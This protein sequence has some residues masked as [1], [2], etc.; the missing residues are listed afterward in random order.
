MKK[1]GLP[2]LWHSL[3]QITVS[4]ISTIIA[5]LIWQMI[6]VHQL[7]DMGK[8]KQPLPTPT[9]AILKPG[10]AASAGNLASVNNLI[11]DLGLSE[12]LSTIRAAPTFLSLS[13][14]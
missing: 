14:I 7:H 9:I 6:E 11:Y 1:S 3:H 10:E 2:S 12:Y 5:L 4:V 8:P 13:F